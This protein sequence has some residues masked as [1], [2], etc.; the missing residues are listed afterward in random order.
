[1]NVTHDG[2][3]KGGLDS[4]AGVRQIYT[5]VASHSVTIHL[6]MYDCKTVEGG[7]AE[8]TEEKLVISG[9]I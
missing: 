1:M 5:D 9:Q 7:G 3:G 4:I 6:T 8:A 2:G